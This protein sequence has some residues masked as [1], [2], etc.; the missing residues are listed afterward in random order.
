MNKSPKFGQMTLISTEDGF[1]DPAEFSQAAEMY[2][3]K[4]AFYIN[5]EMVSFNKKATVSNYYDIHSQ[6]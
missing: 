3:L 4:A 2:N 5:R 1:S 6:R